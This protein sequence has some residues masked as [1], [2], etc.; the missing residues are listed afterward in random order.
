M[1][2]NS[3]RKLTG[4]T[5]V[6]LDT[7]VADSIHCVLGLISELL[8]EY[9]QAE[10]PVNEREELGDANWFASEYCNIWG[11]ETPDSFHIH[12]DLQIDVSNLTVLLG[13]LA[14]L[15]KGALAYGR[16]QDVNERKK[17]ILQVWQIIEM[18]TIAAGF[19]GDETREINLKKLIKR[20]GGKF[21]EHAANNRDLEAELAVLSKGLEN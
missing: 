17:L 12:P 20:F 11:I 16:Q 15:D 8:V 1:K 9:A 14:D 6:K 5:R 4:A 19:D 10:T 18:L 3:Y 13:E 2:I 21:S 7:Q